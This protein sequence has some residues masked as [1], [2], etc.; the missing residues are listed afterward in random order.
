MT[1]LLGKQVV[2]KDTCYYYDSKSP[3]QLGRNIGIVRRVHDE[4]FAIVGVYWTNH[5]GNECGNTYLVSDVEI[6]QPLEMEE[7]L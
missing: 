6:Y 2:L 4:P 7:M 3:Y 5:K 1:D